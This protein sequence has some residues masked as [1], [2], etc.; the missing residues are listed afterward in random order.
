M[1]IDR[2]R[3]YQ[4]DIQHLNQCQGVNQYVYLA[5]SQEINHKCEIARRIAKTWR[6]S[7]ITIN[8]KKDH[9]NTINSGPTIR[10]RNMVTESR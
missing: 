9:Q 10:G 1:I 6:D 5:S 8:T 2:A 3:N 7:N 4:P